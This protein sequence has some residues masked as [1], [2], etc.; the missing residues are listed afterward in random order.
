M[1]PDRRLNRKPVRAHEGASGWRDGCIWLA[2]LA[3]DEPRPPDDTAVVSRS[4]GAE[5][6][7]RKPIISPARETEA[8]PEREPAP[9]HREPGAH[10]PAAEDLPPVSPH[11]HG[12]ST[13]IA[14]HGDGRM[15]FP[16]GE[17][18]GLACGPALEQACNRAY[19]ETK[20]PAGAG[21]SMER[22][23]GLEPTTFCMASRRSSQ[24]SY[25][26]AKLIIAAPTFGQRSRLNHRA[27]GGDRRGSPC[28][29][30]AGRDPVLS[31]ALRPTRR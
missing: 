7:P 17:G 15:P 14:A 28:P 4:P 30:F 9:V 23:M 1:G 26:R 2:S 31:T 13:P 19:R 18:M 22:M 12:R 6:R 27:P 10:G 11:L 25:I 29:P 24:L 20:N 16:A 8:L 5:P 3:H 21:L